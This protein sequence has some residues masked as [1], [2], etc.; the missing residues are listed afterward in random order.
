MDD[1]IHDYIAKILNISVHIPRKGGSL[2]SLLE[3]GEE[4]CTVL[5]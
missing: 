3:F 1:I 5:V 4:R 2:Y